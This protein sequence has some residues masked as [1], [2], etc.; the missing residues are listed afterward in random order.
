MG[1]QYNFNLVVERF[2]YLLNVP[3]CKDREYKRQ[4]ISDDLRKKIF[5]KY[6]NK[7]FLCGREAKKLILH[8]IVP[9]GPSNEK[10][11]VPLCYSCHYFIHRFLYRLYG[12]RRVPPFG[13]FR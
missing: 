8:H 7:C 4:P 2:A 5:E 9:D 6:G 11:V 12:Y 10:N 1:N 3:K 13:V